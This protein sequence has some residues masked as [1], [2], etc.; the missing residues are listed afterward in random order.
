M[1][2]FPPAWCWPIVFFGAVA[3]PRPIGR[4]SPLAS[5]AANAHQWLAW[6]ILRLVGLH[7]LAVLYHSAIRRDDVAHRMLPR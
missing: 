2:Q 3:L 1:V 5:F 4:G 7:V 6:A